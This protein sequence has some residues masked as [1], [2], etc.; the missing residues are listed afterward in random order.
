MTKI[1]IIDD[2]INNKRLKISDIFKYYKYSLITKQQKEDLKKELID[3]NF[4]D[5][6][7][8]VKGKKIGYF[9]VV[10]N[11]DKFKDWLKNNLTI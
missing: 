11:K 7:Y 9:V 2:L 10:N 3:N 8:N 1:E 5:E 4:I 6:I